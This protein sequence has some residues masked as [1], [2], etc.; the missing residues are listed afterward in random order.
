MAKGWVLIHRS[1]FN[2]ELWD[3][4]PFDK[5]RAWIDLIL[6]ANHENSLDQRYK[7]GTV[8]FGKENLSVRW[9]WSRN[10]VT[11]FLDALE[12]KG[13]VKQYRTQGGTHNGTL[14]TIVNYGKY[15]NRGTHNGTQ[16]ESQN[17]TPSK[18]YKEDNSALP[19][20]AEVLG[21]ESPEESLKKW[22]EENGNI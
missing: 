16:N 13:M 14:I 20:A 9:G 22:R 4:K 2:N 7:K 10:K 8:Y 12:E 1:I 19:T 11:R 3:E 5:A 15:Q 6:L 17:E 18:K 21:H